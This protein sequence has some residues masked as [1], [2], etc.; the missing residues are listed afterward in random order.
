MDKL[1]LGINKNRL[2]NGSGTL[3]M[4]IY[5]SA[6]RNSGLF[7]IYAHEESINTLR[8]E[9]ATILLLE[10]KRIFLDFW[11]Y[12]APTYTDPVLDANFD[13]IIKLQ[14]RKMDMAYFN[15]CCNR[16]GIF[17][18]KTEEQRKIFLGKVVPW[19]FFPSRMI[20][21]FVGKEDQIESAPIER[22]CFFCG[23]GW[24]SRSGIKTS[25]VA[26]GIE[27]M[28]S[29]QEL[30]R[31]KPINDD[32]YIK[33]MKSSKYGLVLG[34][35]GSLFSDT[36]NRREM[37]YM[38]L[39]KPLLL[40][41]RP[42]YYNPLIPGKHYIFIDEKTDISKLDSMYNTGEMANNAFQ[43]YLDNA[44]TSGLVKTFLQIT[45]ERLGIKGE[46]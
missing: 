28:D 36:K 4:D 23:K 38:I 10:G 43:W 31:G 34:G 44:S 20:C 27:Y 41:Y 42:Y 35:R 14:A 7:D 33:K 18:N 46:K 24:K 29:N 9:R 37:D 13:L 45:N 22:L 32:E 11:E 25:L 3:G 6:L 26:Q 2:A 21:Q 40:N 8:T 39:K 16:K 12:P 30:R 17:K 15:S 5:L 1:R 19:S